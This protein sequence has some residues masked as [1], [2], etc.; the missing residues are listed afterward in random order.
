MNGEMRLSE[1]R[2]SQTTDEEKCDILHQLIELAL[3]EKEIGVDPSEI[4][5][6]KDGGVEVLPSDGLRN[7]A[8]MPPEV[9]RAY[10]KGNAMSMGLYQ[11]YFL[12]GMFAYYLY[13]GEDYYAKRRV[14]LLDMET[15]LRGRTRVIQ[16]DEAI[17]I[18][19]CTQVSA[20]TSV[21]ERNRVDGVRAFLDYLDKKVP[22]KAEIHFI[23]DGREVRAETYSLTRENYKNPLG[24]TYFFLKGEKYILPDELN[25][26]Y[27]SGIRRYE[28]EVRKAGRR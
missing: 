14:S 27:R 16:P 3:E 26:Q 2:P 23:S 20:M 19:F 11:K 25:I 22:K 28:V 1:L 13:Y 17:E 9:I 8:F 10:A 6:R 12:I 24:R 7:L 18:P 5:L 4:L 15:F 21:N